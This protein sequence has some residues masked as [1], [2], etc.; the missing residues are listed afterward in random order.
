MVISLFFILAGIIKDS[1]AREYKNE[2]YK[3]FL[4]FRKPFLP[5]R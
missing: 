4:E 2:L 1:N 3:A 5:A